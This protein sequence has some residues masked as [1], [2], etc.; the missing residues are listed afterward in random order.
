MEFKSQ[1]ADALGHD[2]NY[3]LKA[4][5]TCSEVY[6]A[7]SSADPICHVCVEENVKLNSMELDI[8]HA[9]SPA[10]RTFDTGASRDLDDGK[11]DYEGFFSP[12]VMQRYA[13]FMHENRKMKDGSLRSADNWQKGMPKE[14]YR[15]SLVRHLMDVWMHGRGQGKPVEDEKTALCAVIFNASGLLFELLKDEK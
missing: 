4:C 2:E 3:G 13:E 6:W 14:A 5:A 10:F 8:P 15:K 11:L 12:A 9:T 7:G 1:Y